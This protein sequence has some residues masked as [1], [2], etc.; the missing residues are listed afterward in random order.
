MSLS[1]LRYH[2]RNSNQWSKRLRNQMMS[3]HHQR[4][5]HHC[6]NLVADLIDL[7]AYIEDGLQFRL[8]KNKIESN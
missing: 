8:I 2:R 1:R 5:C 3:Y 4:L 7:I 6:L